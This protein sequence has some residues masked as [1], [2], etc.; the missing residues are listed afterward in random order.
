MAID[1][2]KYFTFRRRDRIGIISLLS[3]TVIL[4]IINFLMPFFVK[5]ESKFDYAE[6]SAE[7]DSFLVSLQPIETEYVSKLDSFIIARY[8]SLDLFM[9]DPNTTTNEEWLKLGL[10]EKQIGTINNYTSKGGRFVVKDDFRKIYG[11][12]TK[13]YQILEPFIDLPE[14][15]PYNYNKPKE[16]KEQVER[17]LFEFDPNTATNEDFS[18]LGLSEKQIT[19]IN[20]YRNKG[21]KFLKKEDFAKMYVISESE[22]KIFEP[23]I[24]I[25][26]EEKKVYEPVSIPTVDVNIADTALFKKLPGIGPVYAER[27]VKYRESM[28]GFVDIYQVSEVYGIKPETFDNI[29]PYLVI[30]TIDLKK[31]NINFAEYT[32]LVK[33]P[34]IDSKTA[35]LILNYRK[36]NGFYTSVSQLKTQNVIDEQIFNKLER[37]LTV[38]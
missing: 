1:F 37:Y 23:Y 21:G 26:K 11:I 31:I 20:N 35:N 32:D 12:R 16:N 24:V 18:K 5:N 4:L 30:S 29:E 25:Q 38:D 27:I 14:E 13:Q 9:F 15:A 8:D 19:T 3:F 33:H 10:T 36:K 28:G 2:K 7:V 34:Y 17:I 6:F 22:Y